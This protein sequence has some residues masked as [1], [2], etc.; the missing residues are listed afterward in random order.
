[1]LLC[2]SG[3][4]KFDQ[5]SG[6]LWLVLLPVSSICRDKFSSLHSL[7]RSSP[8]EQLATRNLL[9]L[10]LRLKLHRSCHVLRRYTLGHDSVQLAQAM[11]FILRVKLV[12]K[13]AVGTSLQT[14]VAYSFLLLQVAWHRLRS[15]DKLD[16]GSVRSRKAWSSV[17]HW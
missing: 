6:L 14:I 5:S 13:F 17:L 16:L 9:Q 15:L 7:L 11:A 3:V 4:L 1:M 10:D 12:G 8:V 2:L